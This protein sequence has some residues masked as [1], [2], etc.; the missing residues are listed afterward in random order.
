MNTTGDMQ[1]YGKSS[2]SAHKG[3]FVY[4]I[5]FL[6]AAPYFESWIAAKYFHHLETIPGASIWN[7]AHY[8][9]FGFWFLETLVVVIVFE[10]FRLVGK[11]QNQVS[12]H[13]KVAARQGF[14]GAVAGIV[15]AVVCVPILFRGPITL[16]PVPLLVDRF[17]SLQT[18]F[19]AVLIFVAV[20][21]TS[22][23]TFR[24]IVFA[25]LKECAG[26]WA[27]AIGSSAL[28]ACLWPGYGLTVGFLLGLMTAFLYNRKG[29]LLTCVLCNAAFTI[30]AVCLETW[31]YLGH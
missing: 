29:S 4:V 7:V 18:V 17:Y 19:F 22:E 8:L 31:R 5:L 26:F 11:Q 15:L 16:T 20:P 2:A 21:A 28:F 30:T 9:R 23:Y 27:A 1:L 13:G 6:F 12:T 10:V 14:Y 3:M 25:D 24:R